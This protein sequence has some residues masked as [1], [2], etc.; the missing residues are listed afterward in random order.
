[1]TSCLSQ[2]QKQTKIKKI[3][4]TK[5]IWLPS[6]QIAYL[7]FINIITPTWPHVL[8]LVARW[9][10]LACCLTCPFSSSHAHTDLG[11]GIHQ[12]VSQS[13]A[14]NFAD[15]LLAFGD[16]W[17]GGDRLGG[18]RVKGNGVVAEVKDL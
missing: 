14:Q 10:T 4:W 5:E 8:P 16:L 12:Q 18:S 13:W 15:I 2:W 6:K 9:P 7:S 11:G 3:M 1:M 17:L